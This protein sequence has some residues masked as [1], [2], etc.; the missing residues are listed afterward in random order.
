[1]RNTPFYTPP[2]FDYAPLMTLW[3]QQAEIALQM[4]MQMMQAAMAPW[5]AMGF[6]VFDGTAP[7]AA[8]ETA[9]EAKKAPAPAPKASPKPAP[10]AADAPAKPAAAPKP[11]ASAPTPDA[12]PAAAPKAPAPAANTAPAPKAKPTG[13][14]KP[15][16]LSAPR[17]G[18]PDSLVAIKGLGP[19]LEASLNEIGIYHFDQIAGWSADEIAWA[20][21]NLGTIRGRASRDDWKGQAAT[22]A[23]STARSDGA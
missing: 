14:A 16:G 21:E 12:A 15:K 7:V 5:K 23:A 2:I 18:T 11:A 8:P 10:N 22:L 9:T 4:N 1:M 6:P 17:A 19:K 20:D 13:P 3:A